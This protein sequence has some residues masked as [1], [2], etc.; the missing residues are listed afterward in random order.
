LECHYDE[1]YPENYKGLKRK[2]RFVCDQCEEGYILSA[3]GTCHTCYDFGLNNCEKCE[4]NINND[5][6]IICVQC[7]QGYFKDEDG[8]CIRC[9]SQKIRVKGNKCAFCNDTEY[10]GMEGCILCKSDNNNILGCE[11]CAKGYMIK[12]KH[13]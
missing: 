12:I 7:S 11:K 13:A 1:Q 5:N 3:D 2:R 6:K 10:G 4:W 9:N 8:T